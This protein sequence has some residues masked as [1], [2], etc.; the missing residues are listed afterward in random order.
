MSEAEKFS[1]VERAIRRIRTAGS[2]RELGKLATAALQDQG[3]S[4]FT[5]L[6]AS[7]ETFFLHYG[8]YS[9]TWLD[10]YRE[11]E[12]GLIDPVL[13]K[14]YSETNAW[15][16]NA[17]DHFNDSDKVVADFF[18]D[19]SIHSVCQG[20]SV[21][22]RRQDGY[23]LFTAVSPN[24]EKQIEEWVAPIKLIAENFNLLF[25]CIHEQDKTSPAQHSFSMR[26]RQ[27]LFLSA[28]G[29]TSADMGELLGIT[30]RTAEQHIASAKEKMGAR[31]QAAAVGYAIDAG[32]I[33]LMDTGLSQFMEQKLFRMPDPRKL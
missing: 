27:A 23:R 6:E 2:L 1:F 17:R 28:I 15:S 33:Q 10:R 19:A 13:K 24:F 18:K 11:R 31:T 21:P 5:L 26:E 9:D 16:W 29:A 3:F 12:Y 4:G 30:K 8:T 14:L 22:F 25:T 20:I 32:I 7:A